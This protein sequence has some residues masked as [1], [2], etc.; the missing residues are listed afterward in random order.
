MSRNTQALSA[1]RVVGV[2]GGLGLGALS[3]FAGSL[4]RRRPPT[5]YA[6][7]IPA[8]DR[9]EETEPGHVE[10]PAGLPESTGDTSTAEE[11]TA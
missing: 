11:R 2:L 3:G 9:A 7:G 1:R 10:V 5:I 4:L 8:A 6:G